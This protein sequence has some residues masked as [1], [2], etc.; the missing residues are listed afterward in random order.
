MKANSFILVIPIVV[1][2]ASQ[3]NADESFDAGQTIFSRKCKACHSVEEGT[4]RVGPSLFQIFQR[5][6]GS[7]ADFRFS[8]PFAELDFSWDQ[9]NLASFLA[10]P[11]SFVPGTK[12]SFGGIKSPED[13]TNLIRYLEDL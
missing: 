9:E 12:M 8:K 13:V 11:K 5:P 10:N 1:G 2:I 4:H 7:V 6:A 3:V